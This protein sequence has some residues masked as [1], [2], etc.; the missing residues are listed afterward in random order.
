[1]LN[2]KYVLFHELKSET[3][4]AKNLITANIETHLMTLKKACFSH[5]PCPW[6]RSLWLHKQIKLTSRVKAIP[7]ASGSKSLKYPL[8]C[9]QVA[10]TM[11]IFAD[12]TSVPRLINWTDVNHAS[13]RTDL[14]RKINTSGKWRCFRYF[15]QDR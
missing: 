3:M 9:S 15:C 14:I 2:H 1:M 12:W 10:C 8:V 6:R 11:Q 4:K 5:L 13:V 7:N